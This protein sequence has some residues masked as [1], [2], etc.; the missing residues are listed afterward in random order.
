MAN[1]TQDENNTNT[2]EADS[3]DP[4]IGNAI[5]AAVASHLKRHMRGLG[6]QFGSMLDER[7]SSLGLAKKEAPASQEKPA[8]DP[9]QEVEKL[10]GE[11]KAQ[12]LKAFEKE[13]FAEVKSILTGKVRPEAMDTALKVLKANGA[14]K[15]DSRDGSASF[16][17]ELGDVELSEG[18]AEWLEGEGALFAPQAPK[19]KPRVTG[20][21]KAPARPSGVVEE[22]LTPAQKTARAL[23]ARGMTLV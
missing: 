23:Q 5:N 10:R 17:S 6:D 4:K 21:N 1:V 20:A 14:I 12:K 7:L 16:K 3:L 8:A 13:T 19:M 22:N 9:M 15:I 2:Q 18:I 11:L